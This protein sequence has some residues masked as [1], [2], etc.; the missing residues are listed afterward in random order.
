MNIIAKSGNLTMAE[1]YRL[2]KSPDVAKLTT[3]KNQELD[4]ARF[5]VHEDVTNTGESITVAAFETEQGEVFATNS[6]TFTRD[7]LD[8]LTMCK[9][10]GEPAPHRIKVLPKMGKS[11]REYIQCVYLG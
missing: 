3:M 9:E 7:F 4:L 6:P 2:T 8:I 11:G 5:I 10:A 1:M